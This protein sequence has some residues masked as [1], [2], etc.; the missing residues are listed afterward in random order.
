MDNDNIKCLKTGNGNKNSTD[1]PKWV[2]LSEYLV[3]GFI[4]EEIGSEP[5]VGLLLKT[6]QDFG[7]PPACLLEIE[8][9]LTGFTQETIVQINQG[10]SGLPVTIRLFCQ[11]RMMEEKANGG[12]GYFF[13]E[14][15]GEYPAGS[16]ANAH[17]LVDLYLYKEGE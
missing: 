8:K 2:F 7:I 17:N 4:A 13:I 10:R 14:R 12:W 1:D 6:V 5:G 16:S 11:K 15:G 9:T 3:S